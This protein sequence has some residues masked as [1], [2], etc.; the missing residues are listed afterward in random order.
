MPYRKKHRTVSLTAIYGGGR[1]RNRTCTKSVFDDMDFDYVKL[2]QEHAPK[3]ETTIC[4]LAV[5]RRKIQN[6]ERM[7]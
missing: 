2:Y 5:V 4:P 3:G 6:K 7:I 1:S